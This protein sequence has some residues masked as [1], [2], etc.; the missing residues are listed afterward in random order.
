MASA[1][2]MPSSKQL[3]TTFCFE[4]NKWIQ[5]FPVNLFNTYLCI[6]LPTAPHIPSF[7][8]LSEFPTKILYAFIIFLVC[9]SF[10]TIYI[11]AFDQHKNTLWEVQFGDFPIQN[12]P[13][14]PYSP[15]PVFFFSTP[16]KIP[17]VIVLRL[18]WQT[19]FHIDTKVYTLKLRIGLLTFCNFTSNTNRNFSQ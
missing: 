12:S 13:A 8:L 15:S 11:L 2:S 3:T 5:K 9:A 14:T 4:P 18:M 10:T 19:R 1:S 6:I 17:P 16:F 7:I